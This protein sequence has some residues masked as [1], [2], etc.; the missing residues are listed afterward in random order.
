MVPVHCR[1][2]RLQ[3]GETVRSNLVKQFLFHFQPCGFGVVVLPGQY[4]IAGKVVAGDKQRFFASG[5]KLFVD[6][7]V[8]FLPVSSDF[9]LSNLRSFTVNRL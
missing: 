7:A 3:G 6:H 4:R 1:L 5:F 9:I 2:K 8:V